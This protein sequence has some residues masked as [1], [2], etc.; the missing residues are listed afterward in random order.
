MISVGVFVTSGIKNIT[1]QK[2]ILNQENEYIS[3]FEDLTEIFD[4]QFDIIS[5]SQT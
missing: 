1:I 2:S 3:L 4:T 5:A